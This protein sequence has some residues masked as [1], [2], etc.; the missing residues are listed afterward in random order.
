[1]HVEDLTHIHARQQRTQRIWTATRV[2]AAIALAFMLPTLASAAGQ[3]DQIVDDLDQTAKNAGGKLGT[4]GMY[5]GVII[6]LIGVM[7]GLVSDNEKW[8]KILGGVVIIVA[9]GVFKVAIDGFKG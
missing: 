2:A 3:A 6:G 1:M 5:I 8:K 7:A 4:T 9:G